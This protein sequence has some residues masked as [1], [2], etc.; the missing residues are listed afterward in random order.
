MGLGV[1]GNY[2]EPM[3]NWAITHQL[4]E[5]GLN[6]HTDHSHSISIDE[7]HQANP[8]QKLLSQTVIALSEVSQTKATCVHHPI[9]CP[10]DCHC[11]SF[12]HGDNNTEAHGSNNSKTNELSADVSSDLTFSS[13]ITIGACSSHSTEETST[14]GWPLHIVTHCKWVSL[15]EIF[16][17]VVKEPDMP[18]LCQYNALLF[19]PPIS[20][21]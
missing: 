2:L 1:L 12:G 15:T 9:Q 16:L 19:R 11:A 17:S 8:A 20:L 6:S 7:K 21:A 4:A 18:L 14:S 13:D 3:R 5:S 10:P